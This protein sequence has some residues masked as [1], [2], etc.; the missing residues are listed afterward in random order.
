[1][2]LWYWPVLL[3]MTSQRTHL[4]GVALL[5]ARLAVIVGIAALSF[6]FVETPIHRG[7]LAGWRSLVVVPVV[8]LAV[9]LLPL[10]MPSASAVVPSASGVPR[11]SSATALPFTPGGSAGVTGGAAAAAGAGRSASFSSVTPWL[12]RWA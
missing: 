5:A 11:G 10:L 2:Y 6:H 1:M 12:A 7:R 8:A 4:Q 3:V 9:S